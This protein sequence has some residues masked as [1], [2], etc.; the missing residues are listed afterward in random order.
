ME[1]MG[2]NACNILVFFG[3]SIVS[4]VASGA[5]RAQYRGEGEKENVPWIFGVEI[6]IVVCI[7]NQSKINGLV[8][9]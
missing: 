3:D 5:E 9:I 2:L 1:P 8:E 7:F 6:I 4:F